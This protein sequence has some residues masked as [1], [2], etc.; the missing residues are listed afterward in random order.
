MAKRNLTIRLDD[1]MREIIQLIADR[2]IRPLAN[3]M[4]YFLSQGVNEYLNEHQ[5]RYYPEENS[6]LTDSEY[7]QKQA[8]KKAIP[9]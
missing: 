2:E 3:Q 9:F 4:L 7:R 1:E 6:L 5:L 8:A